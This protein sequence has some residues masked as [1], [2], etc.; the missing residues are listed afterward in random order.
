MQSIFPSAHPQGLD[1]LNLPEEQNTLPQG[2]DLGPG[3]L[4]VHGVREGKDGPAAV[5]DRADKSCLLEIEQ[6]LKS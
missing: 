1:A 4:R 6:C 5:G 2:G 3:Y